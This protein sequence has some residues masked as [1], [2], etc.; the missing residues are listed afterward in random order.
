V[1]TTLPFR[2]ASAY[3]SREQAMRADDTDE[4]R[5]TRFVVRTTVDSSPND[6][7]AAW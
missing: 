7:T 1:L 6:I 4:R 5:K 3:A 2:R